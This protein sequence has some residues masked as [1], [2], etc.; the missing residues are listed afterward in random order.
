[1]KKRRIKTI[2]FLVSA[3]IAMLFGINHV[4]STAV[5]AAETSASE[6][7]YKIEDGEVTI[8][9]LKDSSL[10]EIHIP[11]KIDGYP[12]TKIGYSAFYGEENLLTVILPE[13]LTEIGAGAFG[14][15]TSLTSM[16]LPETVRWIG[17]KCFMKCDR[18]LRIYLVRDSYAAKW[19]TMNLQGV[20][21]YTD[22]WKVNMVATCYEQGIRE[23]QC[24][25]CAKVEIG[26][27]PTLTHNYTDW[28]VIRGNKL[29]PP[30]V[31]ERHC[32]HCGDT[33]QTEDWSYAWITVL[34]GVSV[35][36]ILVGFVYYFKGLKKASKK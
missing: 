2:F 11:E 5:S 36:G 6:F 33:Q 26:I 24:A 21:Q 25:V 20:H 10:R 13:G 16:T 29:I 22:D 17:D 4:T 28:T 1:M 3:M 35:V 31:E 34:A 18:L 23:R 12:V 14:W 15:C 8:T 32:I 30:I 19:A 27:I 7:E 9:G